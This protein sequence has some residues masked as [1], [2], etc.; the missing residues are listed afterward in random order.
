MSFH[1]RVAR[2]A[3]RAGNSPEEFQTSAQRHANAFWAYAAV[4][5]FIWYVLSWGWS[6][7]PFA[8]AG[9]ALLKSMS[10]TMTARK[11]RD[12]SAH[13]DTVFFDSALPQRIDL[14]DVLHMAIIDDIRERYSAFVADES[15]PYAG[16]IYRPASVLPYPKATI[17]G[18]L[19]ALLDFVEGRRDSSLL[20]DALRTADVAG[21][22]QTSLS[23]LDDF[24][25]VPAESL[26]T[27]PKQNL[28]VGERLSR[29]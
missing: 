9:L 24:L 15:H 17:S 20:D 5:V 26:P 7:I 28:L 29:R 18:A 13:S 21:T 11:L 6:L 16:C 14:D 27:D 25:E 8:L 3:L 23:N 22:L 19:G 4:G 10:S 1:D 2:D 12:M